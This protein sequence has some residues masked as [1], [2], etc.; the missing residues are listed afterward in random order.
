MSVYVVNKVIFSIAAL[1]DIYHNNYDLFRNINESDFYK[2]VL[3]YHYCTIFNNISIMEYL[4][5]WRIT[6]DVKKNDY[7]LLITEKEYKT[8]AQ[9]I[10]NSISSLKIDNPRLLEV[11]LINGTYFK[12]TLNREVGIIDY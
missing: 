10:Q 9:C 7:K 1:S 6:D 5:Q 11:I 4:T 12:L 3:D 2:M 8:I